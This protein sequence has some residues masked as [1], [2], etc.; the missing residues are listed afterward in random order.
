VRVH[1]ED[2][3]QHDD[4]VPGAHQDPRHE[5][6]GCKRD[7]CACAAAAEPVPALRAGAVAGRRGAGCRRPSDRRSRAARKH[8]CRGGSQLPREPASPARQY[9]PGPAEQASQR[10]GCSRRGRGRGRAPAQANRRVCVRR[11]AR[12]QPSACS[13]GVVPSKCTWMAAPNSA[14]R[15]PYRPSAQLA[16]PSAW[17]SRMPAGRGARQ[18]LSSPGG[19]LV[20]RVWGRAGPAAGR[21]ACRRHVALAG[22]A[23]GWRTSSRLGYRRGW[24]SRR[25]DPGLRCEAHT[26]NRKSAQS[27]GTGCCQQIC[28]ETR[29][30]S[31]GIHGVE[32]GV[33][34]RRRCRLRAHWGTRRPRR[35]RACT[36][37]RTAGSRT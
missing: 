12:R 30:C 26:P 3:A 27:S 20:H 33:S 22:P 4:A 34:E 6:L 5:E 13:S 36:P 1:G 32:H 11:A 29:A 19:R 37:C 25:R 14:M 35:T 7:A 16:R 23:D 17:W 21:E 8:G 31:C 24:S 18:A 2:R 15:L 10:Y 28:L 9:A